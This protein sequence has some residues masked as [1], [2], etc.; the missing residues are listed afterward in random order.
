MTFHMPEQY[1][2]KNG[3]MGSSI[4]DGNNGAFKINNMFVI[5]S[6]YYLW[7]HVSVSLKKRC[8]HWSEMCYIK[9]L[10]WDE[11]DC[12]MQLHPPKSKYINND[13]NV[14]HLWRPIGISIPMPP[15]ELV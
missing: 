14:L 12:V 13:P 15:K 5:A 11:E 7:E 8:L 2:I 4:S 9:D 1:R 10:F 3:E 6:D